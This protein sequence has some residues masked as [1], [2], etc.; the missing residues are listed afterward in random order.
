[1]TIPDSFRSRC[2]LLK[3]L[4][5]LSSCSRV[6]SCHWLLV[7]DRGL[8]TFRRNFVNR[9]ITGPQDTEF[10]TFFFTA[11]FLQHAPRFHP[12]PLSGEWDYRQC[13][14]HQFHWGRNFKQVLDE[15]LSCELELLHSEIDRYRFGRFE[16]CLLMIWS[17]GSTH[18][19]LANCASDNVPAYPCQDAKI[20]FLAD[21]KTSARTWKSCKLSCTMWFIITFKG[22]RLALADVVSNDPN[23]YIESWT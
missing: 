13:R 2:G 1:M 18:S 4:L 22:L 14:C 6:G 12:H 17:G 20:D 15:E 8:P 7:H 16:D 11:D 21:P 9:R 23:G 10:F 5:G 3:L 19:C